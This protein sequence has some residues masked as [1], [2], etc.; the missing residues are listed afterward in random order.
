MPHCNCDIFCCCDQQIFK[1]ISGVENLVTGGTNTIIR[2]GNIT[3]RGFGNSLK[4]YLERK[5]KLVTATG[6]AGSSTTPEVPIAA[7][8]AATGGGSSGATAAVKAPRVFS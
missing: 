6:G 4:A 7:A 1:S 2:H 8:T 3:L 5:R